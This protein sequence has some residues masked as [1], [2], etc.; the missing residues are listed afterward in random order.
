M[1][2]RG[3]VFGLWHI[4]RN[5]RHG[6]LSPVPHNGDDSLMRRHEFGTLDALRGAAAIIVVVW[7]VG[8]KL[9][10]TI[11][12]AYLAV[13]LFFLLSGFVVAHSYEASLRDGWP[14]IRF[15][16]ARVIRLWPLYLLCSA[17]GAALAYATVPSSADL[18]YSV[19]TAPFLL[20]RRHSVDNLAFPLDDPAWSLFCEVAAN[21]FYAVVGF[22]LSSKV[23]TGI[24]AACF[25]ALIVASSRQSYLHV[26]L[27][28]GALTYHLRIGLL[29]ALFGF[30]LGVLLHRTWR[31]GRFPSL[32]IPPWVLVSVCAALLVAFPMNAPWSL[33]YALTAIAIAFPMLIVAAAQVEP[34]GRA[35]ELSKLSARQSYPLYLVHMVLLDGALWL[36][37]RSMVDRTTA[38]IAAGTIAVIVSRPLDRWF[39]VPV[40]AWLSR[41]AG[42]RPA[43]PSA[44]PPL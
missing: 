41:A 42:M 40:R 36:A 21:G 18:G 25:I 27:N 34:R 19:L 29:R 26:G 1:I 24:C 35:R 39:D 9:D 44:A 15:T 16:L 33:A 14:L 4:A 38:M 6:R 32:A 23:L 2:Y 22:K 28:L 12:S 8:L 31:A 10:V 5:I 7:H 17:A 30:L 13:D 3:P 43:I 20:P 37:N 11:G